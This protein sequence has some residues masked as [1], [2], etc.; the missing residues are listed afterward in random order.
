MTNSTNH[1]IKQLPD[2]LDELRETQQFFSVWRAFTDPDNVAVFEPA[3]QRYPLFFDSVVRANFSGVIVALYRL[4]DPRSKSL[5]QLYADAKSLNIFE[6][7]IAQR[8][9][10]LELSIQNTWKK[11]CILRS[12]V[13]GHRSAK[14]SPE[15]AFEKAG[16]TPDDLAAMIKS[17]QQL[18]NCISRTL[19][20]R[21]HAFNLSATNDV[22]D[23]M[24]RLRKYERSGT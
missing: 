14:L 7:R 21:S 12:N 5:R 22:T 1:L 13:F 20:R 2:I 10:N 19:T 18:F 23:L 24:T 15:L 8:A 9:A 16:L 4:Y 3:T 17:G 6:P 11:V